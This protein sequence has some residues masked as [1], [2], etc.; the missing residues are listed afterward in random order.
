MFFFFWK[1]FGISYHQCRWNYNDQEDVNQ[2]DAGFDEHDIPYDVIWLDI[3]HTDSKKY[4]T[5]DNSKFPNPAEMIDNV[6]SKGR[7]M[8][9]IIDPHIKR[10]SGY[11]IHSQATEHQFYVKKKDGADYEGWCWPGS[12]SWVDFFNP[13]AQK[14]WA[15]KFQLDNYQVCV[16]LFPDHNKEIIINVYYSD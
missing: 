15:S 2:V 6:A 7:K 4:M 13:E 14:W 16:C 8:V 10:D 11:H 3:E 12:S 5:W 9:T 1:V